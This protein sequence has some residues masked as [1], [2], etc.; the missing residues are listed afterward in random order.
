MILIRELEK[1]FGK[2]A[3]LR[4]IDLDIGAGRV[5]GIVG[6]NGAGKTTLMKMILGLTQVDDG[7]IW[8]EGER[9]SEDGDSRSAGINGQLGGTSATPGAQTVERDSA[10]GLPEQGRSR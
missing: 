8:V 6:P 1:R 9:V 7:K 2:T 4:G 3:V 10:A 5:T